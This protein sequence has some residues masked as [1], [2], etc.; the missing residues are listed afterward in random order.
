M[1]T[2]SLTGINERIP[3]LP[4]HCRRAAERKR[5]QLASRAGRIN[6]ASPSL[7]ASQPPAKHPE[8]LLKERQ[9]DD[10]FRQQ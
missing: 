2:A 8:R 10:D 6:E 3:A 1:T 4:P 7:P 5:A 9:T